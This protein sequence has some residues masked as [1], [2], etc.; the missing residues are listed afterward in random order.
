MVVKAAIIYALCRLFGCTHENAVR[1]GFLL[2]QGGEFAFVLFTAAASAGAP[3]ARDGVAAGRHRDAV[4]GAD[5]AVRPGTRFFLDARG[6]GAAGGGFRGR[7]RRRADHRLLPLRPDRRADA[8]HRRLQRHHHRSFRRARAQRREIRLPHLFRRR[9]PQGRAGGVRHPP[10]QDRRGLHQQ[11]RHHRPDRRPDP[12]RISRKPGCSCA[13]TTAPIRWSCGPRASTTNCAK[14]SNPACASARR[15]W[16]RSAW[17]RTRPA[18]SSRTCAAATRSGWRC[19]R[20][21]ASRPAATAGIP[22]RSRRSRSSSRPGRRGGLTRKARPRSS[23][24]PAGS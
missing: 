22:S 7:R 5:A 3:A 10:R 2:P 12:E 24:E 8:A 13:P 23:T 4:H 1:I 21:K 20:S 6:R 14:P 18:K 17:T 16:K 19:R 9:H 15:R 11:A